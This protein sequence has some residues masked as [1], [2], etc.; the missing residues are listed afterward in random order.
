MASEAFK[1]WYVQ[2]LQAVKTAADQGQAASSHAQAQGVPPEVK[3][4]MEGGAKV[5]GQHAEALGRLLQGAG[6]SPGS[7]PNAFMDGIQ[8]G[9]QQM[10][11]AAQDPGVR[12]A[13]VVAAAQIATHYFIAAYGTLASNA[14]HLGL[15]ED[16]ATLKGMADEMKAADQ[17]MTGIAETMA[18]ARASSAS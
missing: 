2:G 4:I 11:Q 10:I 9:S 8:K 1:A 17:H 7:M 18:N 13:S 16:A 5:F 12:E 6:A 15:T 14:K 3:T